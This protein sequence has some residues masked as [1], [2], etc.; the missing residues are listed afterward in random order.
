MVEPFLFTHMNWILF[1]WALPGGCAPTTDAS[2]GSRRYQAAAGLRLLRPRI[3][4][5]SRLGNHDSGRIPRWT[6]ML[7][8]WASSSSG[9]ERFS[10]AAAVAMALP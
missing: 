1:W 6:T 8:C 7:G 9:S 5:S 4:R 10:D 3:Q 2:P